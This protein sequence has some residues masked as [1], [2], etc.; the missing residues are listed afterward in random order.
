MKQGPNKTKKVIDCCGTKKDPESLI[1]PPVLAAQHFCVYLR[2]SK[3]ARRL[4]WTSLKWPDLKEFMMR[5]T[6]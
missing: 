4:L 5:L 3:S 6:G 2:H 1:V